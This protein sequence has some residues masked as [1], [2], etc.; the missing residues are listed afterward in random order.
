ML[1]FLCVLSTPDLLGLTAF[2]QTSSKQRMKFQFKTSY[3]P[4]T[5]LRVD[6]SQT[7]TELQWPGFFSSALTERQ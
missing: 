7:Q 4:G 3:I 1:N 2:L 5:G 6:V